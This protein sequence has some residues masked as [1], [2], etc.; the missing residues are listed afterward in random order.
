MNALAALILVRKQGSKKTKLPFKLAS[1]M[2]LCLMW[3]AYRFRPG[4]TFTSEYYVPI[5]YAS[6]F[7]LIATNAMIVW[8]SLDLIQ[9]G[10]NGVHNPVFT[11]APLIGSAATWLLSIYPVQLAI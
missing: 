11:F 2:Q 3:S 7:S 6:A 5:D 4:A 8:L 1:I 10:F 9:N